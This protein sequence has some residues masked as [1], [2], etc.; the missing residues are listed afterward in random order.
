MHP[1]CLV[2]SGD[3]ANARGRARA[4]L[5]AS[6]HQTASLF[7]RR[8]DRPGTP[9]GFRADDPSGPRAPTAGRAGRTSGD[10]RLHISRANW[11]DESLDRSTQRPVLLGVTLYELWTGKRPVREHRS[12]RIDPRAHRTQA[13]PSASAPPGAATNARRDSAA[14]IGEEPRRALPDGGG[15][16]GRSRARWAELASSGQVTPFPLGEHDYDGTLRVP[17]KLYGRTAAREAILEAVRGAQSGAR[18]LALV[19][20]PAGVGKSALVQEV[21]RTIVRGGHLVSGKFD[22]FSRGT[23]YSAL[24]HACSELVRVY[25]ASSASQLE[26]WRQ[27]LRLALGDNARVIV[28]VVPELVVALGEQPE[29]APLPP[30]EAQTRFERTFRRFMEASACK[31]APLVLFLDDL[32]WADTASL[33][34]LELVLSAEQPRASPGHRQL[35][36]LRRRRDAPACSYARAA[37][38][39]CSNRTHPARSVVFSRRS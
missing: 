24:A 23:P 8:R 14:L 35:P 33:A 7:Y 37:R 16:V 11:S 12:P 13:C 21:R 18:A 22:Q 31:E 29:V 15:L 2:R 28:D 27:R 3:D 1:L 4:W 26:D 38:A 34:V 9:G 20:G 30:N 25:L 19:A 5:C 10:A 39:N 17:E 32:Q 6:R 36:R